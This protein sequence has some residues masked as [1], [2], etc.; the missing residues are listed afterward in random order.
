MISRILDAFVQWFH[1]LSPVI[2]VPYYQAGF[3]QTWGKVMI[4][5]RD[6]DG[7]KE[8][9]PIR[10]IGPGV[11][12]KWPVRDV[13]VLCGVFPERITTSYILTPDSLWAEYSVKIAMTYRIENP[14]KYLNTISQDGDFIK[15][16]IPKAVITKFIKWDQNSDLEILEMDIMQYL[17]ERCEE[18]GVVVLECGFASLGTPKSFLHLVDTITPEHVNV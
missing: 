2:I 18:Y 4:E 16:L 9:K 5:T 7:N 3:M 6:S 12:W 10:V 13:L 11:V 17:E 14:V 8:I 1:I 15:E